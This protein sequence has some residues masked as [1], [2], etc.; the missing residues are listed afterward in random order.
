MDDAAM[1]RDY[2]EEKTEEQKYE[3]KAID[4]IDEEDVRI[5]IA[6]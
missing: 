1:E 4:D 6:Q 3:E 2:S 5:E